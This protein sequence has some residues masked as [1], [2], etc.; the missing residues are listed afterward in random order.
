[1]DI[2]NTGFTG[3]LDRSTSDLQ[4]L[5]NAV[6]QLALGNTD[7]EIQD[8]IGAMVTG[9]TETGIAV[10]YDDPTGKLNFDAQTAGDIRYAPVAK[11][12]TN[13]DSHDHSGGDGAQIAHGNLS[14]IGT[15]THAQIDTHIADTNNPHSVTAA[16]VSAIR[17]DGWQA[18]SATGTSGTL[19]SPVFEISFGA[20][21]TA[22]IGLGDRIKITQTTTKYF[23]VVKVGAYSAG[24][25]IVTCYG[26]TDYTLV[27]SG[28]TAITNPYV[29]HIKA[30]FGFPLSP[31]KWTVTTSNTSNC[32]KNSPS[33]STWYGGA[34]LSAT[35]PSIDIP[36]GAWY[37]YWK[38]A[39]EVVTPA[40]TA[41]TSARGTLSTANN[42]ETNVNM[43][44]VRTLNYTAAI[45]DRTAFSPS[46]TIVVTTKTTHYLNILTGSA[47]MT[48]IG[49]RGDSVATIIR[50]VCAYL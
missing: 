49:I 12:V 32:G 29:S 27:A 11:G 9:N 34:G 33:S 1:M 6:D 31:A 19:D 2:K 10:T 15:N 46:D 3:N 26:G 36:I 24:A 5:A 41:S 45:T 25:T 17:N 44:M 21:M 48:S 18:I 7:E 39:I 35:G 20:D 4:S 40:G 38:A 43:T 14:S 42:S 28:T 8:V 13:G 30:P 23:I 22:I 37:V 50:A 47:S 16:Q